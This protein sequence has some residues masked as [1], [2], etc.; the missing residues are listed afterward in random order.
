MPE[1][2]TQSTCCGVHLMRED[3]WRVRKILVEAPT[4]QP[5]TP[6]Y[7]LAGL[8]PI[9]TV[10]VAV[11]GCWPPAWAIKGQPLLF[12][13]TLRQAHTAAT[14]RADFAASPAPPQQYM[15]PE[16]WKIWDMVSKKDARN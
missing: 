5:I 16:G 8:H 15:M 9:R 7:Q 2:V 3:K 12:F 11:Y 4:S 10:K 14:R 13:G 1:Q 6:P